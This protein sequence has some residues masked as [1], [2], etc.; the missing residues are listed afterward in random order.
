MASG[1]EDQIIGKVQTQ[2]LSV[3]WASG[4]TTAGNTDRLCILTMAHGQVRLTMQS[5]TLNLKGMRLTKGHICIFALFE[6]FDPGKGEAADKASEMFM[7]MM[8]RYDITKKS[9]KDVIKK[10]LS[11]VDKMVSKECKDEK[12]KASVAAFAAKELTVCTVNG[13]RIFLMSDDKKI[14]EMTSAEMTISEIGNAWKGIM[15]ISAGY[16]LV[17]DEIREDMTYPITETVKKKDIAAITNA[18]LIRAQKL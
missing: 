1:K 4:F 14:T 13:S 16:P 8:M 12:Y 2:D 18:S 17:K 6:A 7:N 9:A 10:C 15:M 11:K 5:A 3:S